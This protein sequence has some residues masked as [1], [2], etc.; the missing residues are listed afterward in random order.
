[1]I[2]VHLVFFFVN[3]LFFAKIQ[4]FLIL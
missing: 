2:I 1:L 3:N 4:I